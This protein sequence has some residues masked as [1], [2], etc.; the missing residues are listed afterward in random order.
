MDSIRRIL[1]NLGSAHPHSLSNSHDLSDITP[2]VSRSRAPARRF[3][4]IMTVDSLMVAPLP[5]VGDVI[6]GRSA[7]ADG[8]LV[9]KAAGL[10]HA[11]LS[12][13]ATAFFI[14]DLGSPG[15]TQ[16]GGVAL[17]PHLPTP[18]FPGEGIV[19]GDTVLMV[20]EVMREE[21][22]RSIWSHAAFAPRLEEECERACRGGAEFT[23]ARLRLSGESLAS[24]AAAAAALVE[25]RGRAATLSQGSAAI[26]S[27]TPPPSVDRVNGEAAVL[28]ALALAAP[29]PHVV[30]L[31]GT[32]EYELLLVGDSIGRAQERLNALADA[33]AE[34][35]I[36]VK[37]GLA[38]FPADGRDGDV[39][40][41]Q[42]TQR[43]FSAATDDA[44][45]RLAPSPDVL[46][47]LPAGL[48][49]VIEAAATHDGPICLV[50]ERGVGKES[51]ARVIHAR[52]ARAAGPFRAIELRGATSGDLEAELFGSRRSGRGALAEC[53]EGTLFL[54]GSEGL[55]RGVALR[56][57]FALRSKM[58]GGRTAP[59][60]RLIIATDGTSLGFRRPSGRGQLG[61]IVG[62]ERIVVPPVRERREQLPD[63]IDRLVS[64]AARVR[65]VVARVSGEQRLAW[66][67][68]E[69]TG[70]IR[71]L[72]NEV[73]RA[74]AGAARPPAAGA[75]AEV[76][77]QREDL[78]PGIEGGERERILTALASC[79]YN[80]S[81]AAAQLGI[82]R[83]TLLTR[84]DQLG[85]ERPQ[86][87]ATP[88]PTLSPVK[89]V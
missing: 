74:V 33:L 62:A 11:R 63:L 87:S 83:R 19:I 57:A 12:I 45:A 26:G 24:S 48:R 39:L 30:G 82:S 20:R 56:L 41:A 84:L 42:A 36:H 53:R 69:W 15:G 29:A 8:R 4:T 7:H 80:Q 86:K 50:G 60:P 22:P 85:I 40:L 64:D 16:V 28:A 2:S 32:H 54:A 59:T 23:L 44:A 51:L 67:G 88:T 68:R 35:G 43:L 55:S 65:G 14:E 31:Y 13:T 46:S 38:H 9:D 61:D 27:V 76:I 3:V 25:A 6:V 81:R 78:P 49:E 17:P 77:T 18:V 5:E 79:A 21:R 75:V 66:C 47:D 1:R 89:L 37:M 58:A 71:E 10:R 72:K 52:S 70:N 34:N 73:D